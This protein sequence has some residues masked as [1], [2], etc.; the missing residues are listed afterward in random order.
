M[1][2]KL[3]KICSNLTART[4][5]DEKCP[6]TET[7]VMFPLSEMQLL[8]GPHIAS[9]LAAEAD[10]IDA[11]SLAK[12]QG[13]ENPEAW[14]MTLTWPSFSP[15][16]FMKAGKLFTQ[17]ENKSAIEIIGYLS[18][19]AVRSPFRVGDMTE[20]DFGKRKAA[21]FN[22]AFNG[23]S[24]FNV[25]SS[26]LGRTSLSGRFDSEMTSKPMIIMLNGLYNSSISIRSMLLDNNV[27]ILHAGGGLSVNL[28]QVSGP[29]TIYI[30]TL[31]K[32]IRLQ[33]IRS[34]ISVSVNAFEAAERM[35][36]FCR[37]NFDRPDLFGRRI[38]NVRSDSA[39]S[40]AAI[41]IHGSSSG[42][43][44]SYRSCVHTL[45]NTGMSMDEL[46]AENS[47]VFC[48]SNDA[49]SVDNIRL[50]GST[51]KFDA[52]SYL[53][54]KAINAE[55]SDLFFISRKSV[56]ND[57]Q[58]FE[59]TATGFTYSA[60]SNLLDVHNTY[61]IIAP[62][63]KAKRAKFDNSTINDQTWGAI[64]RGGSKAKDVLGRPYRRI[65][66]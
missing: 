52:R 32:E 66:F 64:Q 44:Y 56:A 30:A 6:I 53:A 49:C 41:F 63:D 43:I 48:G 1:N 18:S 50:I 65:R 2:E 12:K 24:S 7:R 11:S 38:A 13:I 42:S 22:Y 62:A 61:K 58:I 29:G 34:Q 59:H 40:N 36:E 21:N 27:L 33:F 14:E 60:G 26:F 4:F 16:I 47:E 5:F 39:Y 35:P 15:R 31:A 45:S 17:N 55:N 37:V 9:E 20:D 57:E 8:L 54:P 23:N 3:L 28:N 25:F 51:V 19:G 10:V 46:D